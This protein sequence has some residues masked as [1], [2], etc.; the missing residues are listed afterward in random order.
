MLVVL[1]SEVVVHCNLIIRREIKMQLTTRSQR[2]SGAKWLRIQQVAPTVS[3][4]SHSAARAPVSMVL[5]LLL[6]IEWFSIRIEVAGLS[7]KGHIPF[8]TAVAVG[9]CMK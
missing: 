8:E 7:S 9:T 3:A 1:R 4:R 6:D 2:H 5:I